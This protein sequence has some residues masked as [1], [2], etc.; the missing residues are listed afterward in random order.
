MNALV[1]LAQIL[2]FIVAATTAYA[3]PFLPK[4]EVELGRALYQD[5]NLSLN[6]NQS[7]ASCHSL[8]RVV[9]P[10]ATLNLFTPGLFVDPENA[11]YGTAVS[12]GSVAGR[13]GGL[14]APSAGYA[15]F[16]PAFHW[17][18]SEGLYVGGQF[19]NGRAANLQE[20]AK[21][22]FLNP[23]EMAMSSR[24][25]VVSRLK[26]TYTTAFNAIYGLNL[27][28]ISA[29]EQAPARADAPAGVEEVYDAMAKAIAMFEKSRYF[30]RFNSKFD[31]YL[32]GKTQLTT[33]ELRGLQLF[34]N[35][36]K[37]NCDACHTSRPSIAPDGS[38]F[39]PLFTDF[40]YDN[41]GL[42]RN[43]NIPNNP[44]PDLGLGGRVDIAKRDPAGSQIGKHKVMGLRNIALT[45]PYGH[46]GVLKTLKEV[47]HFYNTRDTLGFVADNNSPDFGIK[48][49]PLPEVDKNV[50]KDE[51]G[52]LGLTEQEESAIVAFLNTLTDDYPRFGNDPNIPTGT[53]SPYATTAFPS[54]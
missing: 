6:R 1:K 9:K 4:N 24:W 18:G 13:S 47:V 26:E 21:G 49:W 39:P 45:A 53:P 2:T 50:N 37:G 48:G 17:N 40:T 22:P 14:N 35:K 54:L 36:D 15:A 19:W 8:V 51:L 27:E 11:L 31:F 30:N 33:T 41:I 5:K 23:K 20:Q 12:K 32:A 7:C 34:R 43:V 42:P 38:K 16:S 3:E 10:G 28:Q 52:H 44:S 25:A 29:Y 46:N